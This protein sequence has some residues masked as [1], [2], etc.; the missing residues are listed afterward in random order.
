GSGPGLLFETLPIAFGGMWNGA[1]FGS[2]FFFLVAI[3]ALSSSISLIEP[4]VAWLERL[5]I[6]RK[7]ATIALG[8]LC[9]V[10]GAACIYSGKV[11]DSLD[12]ITANIMLPL[13]GLFIAL[14]VGWSMGYTRVRKQVNDI[15]ELL[16]NLWFI[17]LR[18]IAPVGVIIVFLNSLNLI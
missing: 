6:K 17:V 3:A 14:F 5:G 2:A 9:W 18:F 10:G 13:G 7:L 16:F 1:I 11:F 4:G 12:Y 15:P 8:L